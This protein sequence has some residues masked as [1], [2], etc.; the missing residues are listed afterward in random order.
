[1]QAFIPVGGHYRWDITGAGLLGILKQSAIPY[2]KCEG[3]LQSNTC[4]N[5][6]T[7][8]ERLEAMDETAN[9][10]SQAPLTGTPFRN[11]LV[12]ME[13]GSL[14][15]DQAEPEWSTTF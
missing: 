3:F 14:A 5:G 13:V 4:A 2:N 15:P 7:I 12:I 9:R 1:M 6:G 10:L 8:Q 11:Y